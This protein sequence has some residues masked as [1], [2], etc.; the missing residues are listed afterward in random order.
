VVERQPQQ[1]AE[2]GQQRSAASAS[3]VDQRADGVQ[4]VEQE[5]RVQLRLEELQVAVARRTSNGPRSGRAGGLV[6]ED[7]GVIDRDRA[8][9]DEDVGEK[10]LARAMP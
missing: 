7:Q 10:W 8:K 9:Y 5:V 6:A 2:A 3:C 1:V 4:R